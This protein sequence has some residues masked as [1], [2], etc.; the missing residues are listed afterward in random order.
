[1]ILAENIFGNEALFV[2]M[3]PMSIVMIDFMRSRRSLVHL[4]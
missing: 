1:M 3:V 4:Y 2:M